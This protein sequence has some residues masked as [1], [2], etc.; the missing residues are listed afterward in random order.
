MPYTLVII[1]SASTMLASR[2][3]RKRPARSR[4]QGC[5]QV[6]TAARLAQNSR[7]YRPRF[8]TILPA[9]TPVDGGSDERHARSALASDTAGEQRRR[10][11]HADDGQMT[12]ARYSRHHD[13]ARLPPPFIFEARFSAY[14]NDEP[15]ATV[16]RQPQWCWFLP[17]SAISATTPHAHSPKHAGRAASRRAASARSRPMPPPRRQSPLMKMTERCRRH[18]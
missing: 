8:V 10:P 1:Y 18:E 9:R 3:R 12:A 14:R 16:R 2:A 4:F 5:Q 13:I 7:R 11:R 17:I 15:P 6:T